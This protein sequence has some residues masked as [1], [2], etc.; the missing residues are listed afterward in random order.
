M[1][2]LE[3][4]AGATDPATFV[5]RDDGLE[6]GVLLGRSRD[7]DVRILSET[8][9]R[10]HARIKTDG[11]RTMLEDLG[12]SNGTLLNGEPV[13]RPAALFDGDVIAIGEVQIRYRASDDADRATAVAAAET[14][15]A[16]EAS[17]DPQLADPARQAGD[18]DAARRLRLVCR[19]AAAAAEASTP[20]EI[21]ERLLEEIALA[22]APD[23]ATVSLFTPPDTLEVLAGRPARARPPR[24][25]TIRQRVLERGEAVLLRDAHD[26][27]ETGDKPSLVRGRFRSTLTAPLTAGDR[28]FGMIAVEHE[29][30]GAY[31]PGDLEALAAVAALAGMALRNLR[32]L[33]AARAAA[34]ASLL[35]TELPDLIG[36]SAAMEAVRERVRRI[37]PADSAVVIL[38]ETGTGKELVARHLHAASPRA[39]RPFVA[40]NC[41]A[42][43]EGLLESEL[44]GH[45]QGAFTGATERRE[46]RIAEAADGTLFLDEIGD[47]P[48]PMQAKLLRVLAERTFTRVGGSE[49]LSVRCRVIAATHRD[50]PGRVKEGSFREDLWYRLAVVTIDLPPLR[51]R[52]GDVAVLAEALLEAA[53]ARV[54][55]RVPRLT[56][57]AL[58]RLEAHAWPGNVRE[59]GNA[60]ERALVLLDGDE[61][62]PGDLPADVGHASPTV[63]DAK[64]TAHLPTDFSLAAAEARAVAAALRAAGG[65]KGEAARL[66]GVSWPT[67]NRKLRAYGLDGGPAKDG[68][69]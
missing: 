29:E 39:A 37:A 27:E 34:R 3:V 1:R 22:M 26:A 68:G 53:A 59:L 7:A 67:L 19:A 45:E 35:L 9:S 4:L 50:L 49:P 51:S 14:P 52:T 20:D 18:P 65:R 66:L 62:G 24:S 56:P 40:L 44:F 11:G 28:P 2:R 6:R 17:V 64:S 5:L 36:T 48:L 30:A 61:I 10:R 31:G 58:A 43:V 21:A 41:A 54:G 8:A 57:A 38:G 12:S 33:G 25:R 16:V 32:T 47:M 69:D 55:R 15:D 46:G 13:A 60:L 42:I 23:R 63:D